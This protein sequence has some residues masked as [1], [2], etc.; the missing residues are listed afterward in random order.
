MAIEIINEGLINLNLEAKTKKEAI[1]ELSYLMYKQGILKDQNEFIKSVELREELATTYCGDYVA[2]PHG[3]SK[4]VKKPSMAFGRGK[5]LEWDGEG[6]EVRY[7]FLL[8]IPQNKKEDNSFSILKKIN[9]LIFEDKH[10]EIFEGLKNE[11]EFI[12]LISN[13]L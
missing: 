4:F 8:A 13:D 10:V 6:T 2:I 7:I 12:E 5:I 1:E 3:L 11:K 9:D